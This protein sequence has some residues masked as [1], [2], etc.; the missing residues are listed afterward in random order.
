MIIA[1][2]DLVRDEVGQGEGRCPAAFANQTDLF[3]YRGDMQH[4]IVRLKF[5]EGVLRHLIKF[6]NLF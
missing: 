1:N 4:Q 2:L 5:E 3:F 6:V